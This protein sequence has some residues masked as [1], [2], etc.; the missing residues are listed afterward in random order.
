MIS[1]VYIDGKRICSRCMTTEEGG[2]INK[3]SNSGA[4]IFLHIFGSVELFNKS[5]PTATGPDCCCLIPPASHLRFVCREP[6]RYD[7]V[8]LDREAA[9]LWKSFGLEFEKLYYPK[10]ATYISELV[11][12][13]E[14]EFDSKKTN[15]EEMIAAKLQEL[16]ILT[17]RACVERSAIIGRETIERFHNV[18]FKMFTTLSENWTVTR[19][20]DEANISPSYFHSIY[21]EIYGTSP[22]HDLINAR[23]EA[24]KNL[25]QNSKDS[26]STISKSLGYNSPYHFTRQFR[27]IV[28]ESPSKFRADNA[29]D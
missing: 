8:Y 17:N 14:T 16:F 24:A 1:T 2:L 5:G 3:A 10:P 9:D 26:I 13:I 29:R 15:F 12:I 11:R 7:C 27:Q 20:A 21:K 4:Y 6:V 19:L 22:N 25:L 23:I 28:G 18:R